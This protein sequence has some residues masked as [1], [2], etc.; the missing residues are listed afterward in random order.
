MS[1]LKVTVY[2]TVHV[3]Q[4]HLKIIKTYA[5]SLIHGVCGFTNC[6]RNHVEQ[7]TSTLRVSM[8]SASRKRLHTPLLAL[9]EKILGWNAISGGCSFCF[10]ILKKFQKNHWHFHRMCNS[11]H[12]MYNCTVNICVSNLTADFW[13]DAMKKSARRSLTSGR[14]SYWFKVKYAS[15]RARPI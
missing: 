5:N 10:K 14:C 11:I 4:F 3:L 6:V 8:R 15:K 12:D 7:C 2:T 13:N 1:I 9:E